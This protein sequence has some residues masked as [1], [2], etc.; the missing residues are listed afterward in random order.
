MTDLQAEQHR[1]HLE[2]E[3][4]LEQHARADCRQ[5]A[6]MMYTKLPLELRELIYQYLYLED[7]PIPVGSYHFT[8]YVPEPLRSE[9]I[10]PP[11]HSEPFIV[12]PEG[13]TKQ[14]HSIERDGNIIYPDS[15]L[16]NPAYLGHA[17]AR[18]A[19]MYYY[20][21]NTFT[22]CTLENALSDFL[23]RDP[24]H[25]FIGGE[26][27]LENVE[28]LGLLPIDH[29]RNLEI[30]V[31]YEHYFTYLTFYEE[32]QDGEKRFIQGI[33]DALHDFSRR[34]SPA[35]A[36]RLHVEICMMSASIPLRDRLNER[37][38]MNVLEA[39]RVPV[40]VL[41]HDLGADIKV[42]H[43][44]DHLSP[45]PKD[46]SAIFQLSKDQWS[47]EKSA[48]E[49]ANIEYSPMQYLATRSTAPSESLCLIRD[50]WGLRFAFDASCTH[51]IAEFG[52]WPN[53]IPET[54]HEPLSSCGRV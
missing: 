45:F 12:M 38:H 5:L 49:A 28:P 4:Q 13:A 1:L 37:T 39:I 15:R 7:G 31:K 10:N 47:K 44:D 23:F 41:K 20:T 35:N 42:I 3:R 17:V 24:I 8:V 14:D 52:R 40:Y 51:P 22:V 6:S 27:G 19:S 50:R 36:S 53:A 30:R 29:I 32:L 33:F 46:K 21:S 2:F 9:D 16:L 18:D 25:N 48:F 34:I 11:A 54:T 26:T 43:Y